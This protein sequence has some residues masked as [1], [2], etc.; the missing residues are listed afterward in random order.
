[1]SKSDDIKR[2]ADQ[3]DELPL[4]DLEDVAGGASAPKTTT[5]TLVPGLPSAVATTPREVEEILKDITG[6]D[7]W[8]GGSYSH[9]M[10][11]K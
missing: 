10:R 6:G 5:P 1:M 2:D 8:S 3:S 4:D 7:G 9:P 11:K